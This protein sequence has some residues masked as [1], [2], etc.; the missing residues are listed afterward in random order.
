M[1]RDQMIARIRYLDEL[2]RRL[3]QSGIE[4]PTPPPADKLLRR[5]QTQALQLEREST[6]SAMQD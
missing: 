4:R 5:L 2:L 6:R 1:T 3:E